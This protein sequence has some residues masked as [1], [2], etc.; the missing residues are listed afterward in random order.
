[1]NGADYAGPQ[2]RW[3][4]K[5][6]LT[7][8]DAWKLAGYCTD[9]GGTG[10]DIVGG[11]RG[12]SWTNLVDNVVGTLKG[13][14]SQARGWLEYEWR[15]IE[16]QTWNVPKKFHGD[17]D[18]IKKIPG[19]EFMNDA[20]AA[21]RLN[22]QMT[23]P[24]FDN[25]FVEGATKHGIMGEHLP[26]GMIPEQARLQWWAQEGLEVGSPIVAIDYWKKGVE[27]EGRGAVAPFYKGGSTKVT[28]RNTDPNLFSVNAPSFDAAALREIAGSADAFGGRV[29]ATTVPSLVNK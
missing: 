16:G 3:G 12:S 2:A 9:G 15:T 11:F 26:L 29:F 25:V 23:S 14:K 10:C 8:G 19:Q 6:R 27:W 20:G 21:A 17:I 4:T 18:L 5:G 22:G 1:M 13:E 24:M 28:V 7:V